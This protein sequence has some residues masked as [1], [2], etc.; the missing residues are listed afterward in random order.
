MS[1]T[2]RGC[3]DRFIWRVC[4][5]TRLPTTI[6]RPHHAWVDG[7]A[8]AKRIDAM[9]PAVREVPKAPAILDGTLLVAAV[10]GASSPLASASA[11]DGFVQRNG[12][13]LTPMESPS[14]SPGSTSITPTATASAVRR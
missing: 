14:A 12:D 10:V 5:R 8:V 9:R 11:A 3:F 7:A 13:Q 2:G 4:V 1:G 6:D